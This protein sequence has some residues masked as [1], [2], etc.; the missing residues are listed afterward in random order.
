MNSETKKITPKLHQGVPSHKKKTKNQKFSPFG[1]KLK[2]FVYGLVIHSDVQ[3][4]EI[5]M[6]SF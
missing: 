3:K 5:P 6:G 4:Y 2:Y 1:I